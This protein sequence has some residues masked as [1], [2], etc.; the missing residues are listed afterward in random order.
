VCGRFYL[1]VEQEELA[2][3]FDLSDAPELKARYNI[4]PSQEIVAIVASDSVR[5]VRRFRW[6]LI[7]FWAKDEKIGYRTINARSE[8][9]ETKPAFRAAFRYRRCLIPASGY[10]EWKVEPSG[11]QPYCIRPEEAPL[12]AFAGLYEHW[13]REP[14]KGGIDSCTIIVTEATETLSTIHN[15]MPVILHPERFATWLNP[16][17]RAIDK[18]KVIL[19]NPPHSSLRTYPVSKQVGNPGFED[20]LC[21][22]P[23]A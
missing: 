16:N 1:D 7:P 9:V 14:G 12:F 13:E 15:R 11:K 17:E 22:Q 10:Y 6:G 19:L 8:T 20:P 5:E 3:Y 23:L 21:I 18:L 2:A 4:A